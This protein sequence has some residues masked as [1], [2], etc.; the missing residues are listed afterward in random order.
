MGLFSFL[1]RKPKPDWSKA[2][3]KRHGVNDEEFMTTV[4]MSDSSLKYVGGASVAPSDAV[5]AVPV[6]GLYRNG[7]VLRVCVA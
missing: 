6:N 2:E 7:S 5:A 3:I 4:P 1:K